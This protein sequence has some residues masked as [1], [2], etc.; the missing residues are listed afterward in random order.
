VMPLRD[1]EIMPIDLFLNSPEI[2]SRN[3]DCRDKEIYNERNN[4]YDNDFELS[5]LARYHRE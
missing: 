1:M 2:L 5:Q 4:Q 3:P